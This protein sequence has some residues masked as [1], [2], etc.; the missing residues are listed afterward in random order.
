MYLCDA[1]GIGGADSARHAGRRHRVSLAGFLSGLSNDSGPRGE[2][3]RPGIPPRLGV[4]ASHAHFSGTVADAGPPAGVARLSRPDVAALR[5]SQSRTAGHAV[6]GAGGARKRILAG[7]AVAGNGAGVGGGVHGAGSR[8]CSAASAVG[9]ETNHLAGAHY[10]G[11]AGGRVVFDFGVSCI[12]PEPVEAHTS[13]G[14][15]PGR[16]IRLLL[17]PELLDRR[18]ILEGQP[19][20]NSHA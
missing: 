14:G 20:V 1:P 13:G 18:H 16:L 10:S 19:V 17:A 4:P 15:E 7:F 3:L 8:R 5:V 11:D 12:A 6:A 2:S 9:A